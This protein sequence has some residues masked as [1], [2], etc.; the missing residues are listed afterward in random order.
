MCRGFMAGVLPATPSGSYFAALRTIKIAPGNFVN[1]FRFKSQAFGMP[2]RK[3][4]AL[5]ATLSING[6]GERI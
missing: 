4:A 1:L 2:K 5:E 3:R 6:R